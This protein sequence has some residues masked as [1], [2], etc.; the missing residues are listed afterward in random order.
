MQSGQFTR[1]KQRDP[2]K[3]YQRITPPSLI[4]HELYIVM[5]W[6]EH[7]T[8]QMDKYFELRQQ[9]FELY[10]DQDT[11][12][13]T[14]HTSWWKVLNVYFQNVLKLFY[15][16]ENNT[17]CP[18]KHTSWWIVLNVYFQNVLKLFYSKENNKNIKWHHIMVI[19]ISK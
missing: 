6:I 17:G 11:G 16:K 10:W 1:W 13:P 12:C 8:L 5:L 4:W 19:F 9:T 15:T 3:L 2:F 7:E 14:K 18:T